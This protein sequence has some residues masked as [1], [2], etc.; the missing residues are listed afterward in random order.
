MRTKK[1]E[2]LWQNITGQAVYIVRNKYGLYCPRKQCRPKKS[3]YIVQIATTGEV[4][5]YFYN[6]KEIEEYLEEI[7]KNI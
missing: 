5:N 2:E 3:A 7:K 1:L 4:L 6:L